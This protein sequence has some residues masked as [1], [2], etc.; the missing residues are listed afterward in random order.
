MRMS[1]L[2][3]MAAVVCAATSATAAPITYSDRATFQAAA[4]ATTLETFNSVAADTEFHSADLLVGSLT[5]SS[6]AGI[7]PTF[8]NDEALVNVFPYGP[9]SGGIDG[10]ALVDGLG[11]DA[12]EF[13]AITLPG[14]VTAFGFDFENYDGSGD[15][16][17][18]VINGNIVTTLV[19]N[20]FFG[21]IDGA[22]PFNSVVFRSISQDGAENG[23]FTALDNVEYSSVPEPAT[24]ILFSAGIG[25]AAYRRRKRQ[26]LRATV[27]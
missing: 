8:N 15:A 16:L 9:G 5:L 19:G 26:S 18:V 11:L 20:G 7:N 22:A 17:Q 21:F 3:A 14:L 23:T 1:G 12:D 27:L 2:I 6:N 13:I 24:L 4:G 25:A 10:T